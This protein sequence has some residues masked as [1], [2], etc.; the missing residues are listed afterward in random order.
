MPCTKLYACILCSVSS[1]LAQV[2]FDLF[3]TDR[4]RM[5]SLFCLLLDESADDCEESDDRLPTLLEEADRCLLS[6]R[7]CSRLTLSC[8]NGASELSR[9]STNFDIAILLFLV[10]V[11]I[12]AMVV[13]ERS[14]LFEVET[15]DDD[16]DVKWSYEWTLRMLEKENVVACRHNKGAGG[17]SFT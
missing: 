10:A 1:H 4:P 3:L 16:R 11:C 7:M 12:V 8:E 17:K 15:Y 2:L 14:M 9:I 5:R 13:G 6:S